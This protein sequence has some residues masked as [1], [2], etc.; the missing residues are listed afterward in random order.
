MAEMHDE[1]TKLDRQCAVMQEQMTLLAY[2]ELADDARHRLESHV[3]SCDACAME[4]QNVQALHLLLH[5]N[6]TAE[7]SAS[8]LAGARM[9]LEEALD[10]LPPVG[11]VGRLRQTLRGW[12]FHLGAAP[13]LASLLLVLGF[14][15]GG[16]A[17]LQVA[18]H[19]AK[20]TADGSVA[21]STQ[22][23]ALPEGIASIS[24]VTTEPGSSLVQVRYSR[25]VP[26]TV[27]ADAKDPRIQQLLLLATQN[28]VNPG[29]RVDSVGLLAD[30][31][32]AGECGGQDNGVRVR[33]ALMASLRYDK[34]AG[35]RLKA[36]DGLAGYVA[37]DEAV[38]DSVLD[39][40]LHDDNP[41]VRTQAIQLLTPVEADGSVRQVLHTLATDDANPYIR[42]V[43]QETLAQAPEIQ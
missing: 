33:Q 8:L 37:T 28:R 38:R 30:Q 29:V 4:F 36:L 35:V 11:T 3:R 19:A 7:P 39:A 18:R 40:L 20:P 32:R 17:G 1:T 12:A 22:P 26:G 16:V 42:T 13:A 2:G 10:Q 9:R 15:G 5:S 34:N 31:C 23:G 14:A 6:A 41:G 21:M 43:S 24:G 25:L 27:E